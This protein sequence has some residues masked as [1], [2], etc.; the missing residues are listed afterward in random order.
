MRLIRS[1]SK[2]SAFQVYPSYSQCEA[3]PQFLL[4]SIN[5]PPPASAENPSL[6]IDSVGTVRSSSGQV[7]L[8]I[9]LSRIIV[10]SM[11]EAFCRSV[12]VP[13]GRSIED[14]EGELISIANIY[15]RRTKCCPISRRKRSSGITAPPG[16]R[17]RVPYQDS[18]LASTVGAVGTQQWP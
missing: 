1:T 10:V 15:P 9:Q 11:M 14:R 7:S 8:N 18:V 6:L 16:S 5:A 2:T 13:F 17:G 12:D 3:A 4:D